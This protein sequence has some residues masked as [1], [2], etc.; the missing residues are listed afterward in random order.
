MDISLRLLCLTA[1]T[2]K[3]IVLYVS[4]YV[5]LRHALR[6][7]LYAVANRLRVLVLLLCTAVCSEYNMVL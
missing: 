3:T 5:M 1:H 6:F 7:L 2:E 4:C